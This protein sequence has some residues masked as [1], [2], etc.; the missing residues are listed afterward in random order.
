M[1]TDP[2]SDLLCRLRNAVRAQH[3][4]LVLPHSRLEES[5]AQ[6]LS[7]SADNLVPPLRGGDSLGEGL[8]DVEIERDQILIDGED[9][10]GLGLRNV[11]FEVNENLGVVGGEIWKRWWDW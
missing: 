4:D 3:P 10:F 2:I 1:L 9:R 11:V 6:V 5:I 7:Q 8:A